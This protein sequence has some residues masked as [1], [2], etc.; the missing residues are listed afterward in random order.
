MSKTAVITGRVPEA[1][2]DQLDRL[3]ERMDRSRSWVVSQAI[4]AFVVAETQLLD[5]LD[6]AERQI[7]RGEFRTQA[8]MEEWVAELRRGTAA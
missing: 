6:E 3:A 5:S 7:D 1:I 2:S 4:E 8:Q